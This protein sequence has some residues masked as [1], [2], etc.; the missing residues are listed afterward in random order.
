M[1]IKNQL[2]YRLLHSK[3]FVAGFVI[4]ILMVIIAIIAPFIVVHDPIRPNL[5]N[6]LKAPDYFSEGW[7]GN[8]LGADNLGRDVLTRLLIGARY[9]LIIGGVSIFFA[10]LLGLF[11]GTLAGY[12][13]GWA[14]QVI[15]RVADVQMSMPPLLLVVAIVAALGPSI[16]NLIIVMTLTTWP[17]IGRMV[18]SSVLVTRKT[19]F[20]QASIALGA[21]NNWIMFNQILPNVLTPLLI[22][23]TQ[24]VGYL[25]ILESVLSFLGIG[26][27]PPTPSWGVLIADGRDFIATAPWTV[28]APGLAL[29][30]L[31]LGFNFIGDGLRDALDP[32][33]KT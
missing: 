15:M 30:L 25:I 14:D 24:E 5:R 32:R 13:G 33:M 21:D 28:M 19:E 20:V 9:S 17:K 26:V 8:V 2:L 3:F 12:Y 10:V 7:S 16:P 29:C 4:L 18:R 22:L 31:I 23:G 27:Q 1:K 11:L 6:S